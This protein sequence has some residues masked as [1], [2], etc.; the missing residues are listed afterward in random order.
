VIIAH[1]GNLTIALETFRA[2]SAL[3]HTSITNRNKLGASDACSAVPEVLK[4]N[5]N[6]LISQPFHNMERNLLYWGVRTIADLA[7]NNPNNQSKLGCQW[8][9]CL[10]GAYVAE[11]LTA[12]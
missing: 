3:A 9:L 1:K 2:I 7:A 8:C 12:W 4:D 6:V 10:S 5:I 11:G